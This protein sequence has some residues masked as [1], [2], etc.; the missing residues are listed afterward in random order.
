MHDHGEPPRGSVG[1]ASPPEAKPHRL[2]TVSHAALDLLER[3]RDVAGRQF[4]DADLE[5][6]LVRVH[7]PPARAPAGVASAGLA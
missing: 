1:D 3:G 7:L 6:Q 4:L 2:E 5:Q